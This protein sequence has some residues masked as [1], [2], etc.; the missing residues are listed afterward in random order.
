MNVSRLESEVISPPLF[1]EARKKQSFLN[2]LLPN[3]STK[4]PE[5]ESNDNVGYNYKYK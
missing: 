1:K 3:M 5:D 2:F 4:L